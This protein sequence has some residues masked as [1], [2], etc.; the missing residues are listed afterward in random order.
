DAVEQEAAVSQLDGLV[1][2]FRQ[3]Q[4]MPL[5][6]YPATSFAYA[7]KIAD[8]K[9]EGTAISSAGYAW[10]GSQYSRGDLL[11]SWFEQ[12]MRGRNPLDEPFCQ[13]AQQVYMPMLNASG[14][15]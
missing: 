1:R 4:N 11:D 2:L 5:P 12:A 10:E 9:D 7:K 6:F 3:G 8:G 14:K 15:G 13:I